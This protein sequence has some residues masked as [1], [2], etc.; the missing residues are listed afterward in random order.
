MNYLIKRRISLKTLTKKM[1][2]IE[3]IREICNISIEEKRASKEIGSS[4]EADIIIELNQN[5]IGHINVD[6]AEL[7]I[8]SSAK[9]VESLDDDDKV[10]HNYSQGDSLLYVGR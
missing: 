6:F 8:T 1:G 2:R 9:V 3:K 4:L 5:F 10:K 7:T